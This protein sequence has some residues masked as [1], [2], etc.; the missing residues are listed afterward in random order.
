MRSIAW[1]YFV[2]TFTRLFTFHW[3]CDEYYQ[4][5]VEAHIL[6]LAQGRRIPCSV[7][8]YLP[9]LQEKL[10]STGKGGKV[11]AMQIL[12]SWRKSISIN[13]PSWLILEDKDQLFINI[14][15]YCIQ[16]L[17]QMFL[18]EHNKAVLARPVPLP[19]YH[20]LRFCLLF[21]ALHKP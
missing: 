20:L 12:S 11:W 1:R 21:A 4:I 19:K 15:I 13:I 6:E 18:K 16:G 14:R 2:P 17:M 10:F 7:A 5:S 8:S 9:K 3:L